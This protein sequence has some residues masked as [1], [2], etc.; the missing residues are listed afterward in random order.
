[1]GKT[2]VI[3]I[4]WS[5]RNRFHFL[6]FLG[7]YLNNFKSFKDLVK[8]IKEVY[9]GWVLRVY[10]DT[11]I[12]LEKKCEIEC[13]KDSSGNY[14]DNADFCDIENLP[15]IPAGYNTSSEFIDNFFSVNSNLTYVH[16]SMWRYLAIGDPFID[17]FM[18]RDL[19]MEIFEREIKA[20]N[21]WL[22]SDKAGHIM[23]DHPY[24]STQILGNII[25]KMFDYL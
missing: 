9:P 10:H 6:V 21:E 2:P 13:L 18:S 14:Y 8:R 4:F 16:S 1:M 12:R 22:G 15:R 24:H 19:D 20:V 11:T 23:R 17:A 25:S 7:I 3:I 5:V